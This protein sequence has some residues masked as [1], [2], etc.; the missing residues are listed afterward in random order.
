MPDPTLP[1]ACS[2]DR[3]GT[4]LRLLW[5]QWQGAGASMVEP[6]VPELPLDI[7]RRGYAV[8]TAVLHMHAAELRHIG[9]PTDTVQLTKP[10]GV[11]R[12]CAARTPQDLPRRLP[13]AQAAQAS[14]VQ[15]LSMKA[16]FCCL[17]ASA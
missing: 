7:V 5:P 10:R 8:G 12:R 1:Q 17:A 11:L 16:N 6:L 13:D 2:S 3:V 15:A 14:P 9:S 4:H